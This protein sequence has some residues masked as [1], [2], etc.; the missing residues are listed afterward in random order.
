MKQSTKRF[1]SM[2]VGFFLI[3]GTA[4]LYFQFVQS[5]YQNAQRVKGQLLSEEAFLRDEEDVINQVKNLISS[6]QGQEQVQQAVSTALPMEEDVPGAIAQIAGIAI[7][8][9][10]RVGSISVSAV[11]P[12]TKRAPA[13]SASS[14]APKQGS[15]QSTLQKPIGTISL[16]IGLSGGYEDL[17]SFLLLLETNLLVFDVKSISMKPAA[18]SS[19]AKVAVYDA[20]EYDI[21]VT[22]YYQ[23]Q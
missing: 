2:I 15:F 8:S 3:L 23:G 11:A 21:A 5:A 19:N 1:A 10:L 18:Q 16:K 22:T 17:K 4:I 6:Y 14:P 12:Q 20:F 9:G 13:G 7:Q